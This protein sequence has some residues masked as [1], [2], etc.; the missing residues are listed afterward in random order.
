[1]K[2]WN[3]SNKGR[4]A[5]YMTVRLLVACAIFALGFAGNQEY[6]TAV[7]IPLGVA[8]AT[9]HYVIMEKFLFK[10]GTEEK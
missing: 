4:K 10:N 5:L 3:I 6:L 8:Y 1:M 9:F 7:F 2:S